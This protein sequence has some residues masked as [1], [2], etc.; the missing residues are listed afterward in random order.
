MQNQIIRNNPQ[1]HQ[2]LRKMNTLLVKQKEKSARRCLKF[3]LPR[4]RMKSTPI[5]LT[6]HQRKV[7]VLKTNTLDIQTIRKQNRT[8]RKTTMDNTP[9]ITNKAENSPKNPTDSTQEA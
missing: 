5:N 1:D 8:N 6:K 7:P 9:I 4:Q 3:D 2:K